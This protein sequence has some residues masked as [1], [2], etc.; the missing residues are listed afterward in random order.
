MGVLVEMEGGGF[1]HICVCNYIHTH[2]LQ[3]LRQKE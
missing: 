2:A 1:A 3:W